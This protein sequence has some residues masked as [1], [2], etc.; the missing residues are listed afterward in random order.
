MFKRAA[1]EPMFKRP[2]PLFG[3]AALLSL[4]SLPPLSPS[5]SP[6]V[7]REKRPEPSARQPLPNPMEDED[8]ELDGFAR[9]VTISAL[10]RVAQPTRCT[11]G[12]TWSLAPH[13]SVDFEPY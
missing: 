13:V 1:L 12:F 11:Q 8:E 3:A 2:V 7:L 9:D 4:F 5:S 6:L 10:K